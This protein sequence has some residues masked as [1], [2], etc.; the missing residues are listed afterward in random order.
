MNDEKGKLSRLRNIHV[1]HVESG[2]KLT[3][4][5]ACMQAHEV[6]YKRRR[7]Q[8]K[9][10]GKW[11]NTGSQ[12]RCDIKAE[13]REANNDTSNRHNHLSPYKDVCMQGNTRLKPLLCILTKTVKG[14]NESHL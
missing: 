8:F 5:H 10:K 9:G 3:R 2:F 13:G 1:S 12:N 11:S 7:K 6:N 14:K 4:T